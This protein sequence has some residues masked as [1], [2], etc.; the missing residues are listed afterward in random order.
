MDS[1]KTIRSRASDE[2]IVKKSRFI[3][4]VCPVTTQ[5]EALEF[6]KEVSK[7]YWDATHNVYAYILRDSGVKRF[8]DD[9]EPQG[10]AGIP[11]LDVIEKSGITDCAVVITRYF[12]GIMLGAGGLVRAYAHSASIALAAGG[13]VTRAVCERLVIRCDYNF[14]GRLSSLIPECGGIVEDSS[15]ESDVTVIMRIPKDK[16]HAFEAKLTDASF[17][18]YKAEKTDEFY[19]DID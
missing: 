8:S 18:K 15:F 7:K 17:G 16:S 6:I 12:G 9:G 3:G 14:Y 10:T 1:Y 13:T 4:S 19:A 5:E 11:A 2:Y